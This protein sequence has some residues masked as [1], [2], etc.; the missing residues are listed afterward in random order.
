METKDPE[1]EALATFTSAC[2][3]QEA[4]AERYLAAVQR[5]ISGYLAE[6]LAGMDA[7]QLDDCDACD[8]AHEIV[9]GIDAVIYTHRARAI[10][11]GYGEEEARHE[12]AREIGAEATELGW[13]CLAYFVLHEYACQEAGEERARLMC[14]AEIEEAEEVEA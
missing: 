5:R 14:L 7:E 3:Q 9:D 11:L 10:V 8:L 13:D 12:Y 6:E 1:D 4:A 2:Y